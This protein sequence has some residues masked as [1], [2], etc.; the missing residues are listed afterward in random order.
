[1]KTLELRR[2]T[3]YLLQ[4]K[5]KEEGKELNGPESMEL[6]MLDAIWE[7]LDD[8]ED[9]IFLTQACTHIIEYAQFDLQ[10][11]IKNDFKGN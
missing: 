10:S 7:N 9:L 8:H 2:S 1:M 5:R 3:L 6:K 11:M 4:E